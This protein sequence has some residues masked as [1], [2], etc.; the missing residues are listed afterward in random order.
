M[1]RKDCLSHSNRQEHRQS[2]SDLVQSIITSHHVRNLPTNARPPKLPPPPRPGA[3]DPLHSNLPPRSPLAEPEPRGQTNHLTPLPPHH[4]KDKTTTFPSGTSTV[5][6]PTSDSPPMDGR[7]PSGMGSSIISRTLNI[8]REAMETQPETTSYHS[9]GNSGGPVSPQDPESFAKDLSARLHRLLSHGFVHSTAGLEDF[10]D[11]NVTGNSTVLMVTQK[12][13]SPDCLPC[14]GSPEHLGG[15]S[16]PRLSPRQRMDSNQR[17]LPPDHCISSSSGSGS[18][19]PSRQQSPPDVRRSPSLPRS[20]SRGRSQ[21][22]LEQVGEHLPV[23]PTNPTTQGTTTSTGLPRPRSD[24]HSQEPL[25]GMVARTRQTSLPA[26]SRSTF[27]STHA[28]RKHTSIM[29]NLVTLSRVDFLVHTLAHKLPKPLAE[30]IARPH[31]QSTIN[32]YQSAWTVF[33]VWVKKNNL[34]WITAT[35]FLAFLDHL[36]TRLKLNPQTIMTYRNAL[37]LP[38]SYGFNISTKD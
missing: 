31:S 23:P 9:Q 30:K 8:H 22:E 2:P 29:R 4:L 13:R 14:P 28:K 12:A 33:Q 27:I 26:R 19:C 35:T 1:V 25:R 37:D 38:L 6:T 18:I 15:Q 11:S 32:Q 21:H 3:D 5:Q 36:F 24:H 10:P 34:S 17:I 7:L 20:N 16:F